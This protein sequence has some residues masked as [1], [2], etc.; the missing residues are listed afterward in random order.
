MADDVRRDVLSLCSCL[1]QPSELPQFIF[2]GALRWRA[3]RELRACGRGQLETLS[4]LSG[5]MLDFYL[6]GPHLLV[7]HYKRHMVMEM[8][9]Q[10][11]GTNHINNIIACACDIH[12]QSH[13]FKMAMQ[14]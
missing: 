5:F 4:I 14:Y 2:A 7:L 11:T 6:S 9:V 13:V 10:P 1:R 8:E 12:M 3:K